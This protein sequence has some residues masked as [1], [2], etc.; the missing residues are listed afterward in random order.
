MRFAI[1]A[2]IGLAALFPL[3]CA[4][5]VDEGRGAGAGYLA[6]VGQDTQS[7]ARTCAAGT[8]LAG[9]DVSYYQGTID[10]DRVANAGVEYAFIRVSDGLTKVDSK[11]NR[12]WAEARR[13]G[14]RRSVYQFFRPH[15]DPIAQANLLL[16]RMGPLEPGDLPPVIDVEKDSGM[17]TSA[18]AARVQQW[19]DHVE[20]QLGVR[21]IIYSGPYFWRDQVG[22][23]SWA[24]DY[25]LWVAHYTTGCPLTPEPW[26]TWT[27]HQYTDRG[28]VDGISGNVDRNF[29]NGTLADLDA[30]T[31]GGSGPGIPMPAACNAMPEAGGVI[32]ETDPCLR[33]NGPA[34]YWRAASGGH[35]SD[36][37]WTGA[38]GS[39]QAV[40]SAEWTLRF[41]TSGAWQVD[42]YLEGGLGT[43]RLATYKVRHADGE[44]TVEVDQSEAD[45]WVT[46]GTWE[47]DADVAGR[48]MLND[49][50]GEPSSLNRRLVVDALA[51][52]PVDV[53]P[54]PAEPPA[55]ECSLP[56]TGGIVEEDG[57]CT[58]FG[59][60][61]EYLRAVEGEGHGG[62]YLW[63]GATSSSQA[64]NTV[65]WD[66]SVATT[67]AW[68]IEAFVEDGA[69]TSQ[70][71]GYSVDH[72]YGTDEVVVDQAAASGF[73]TLGVFRVDASDGAS[74]QLADNTGESSSLDRKI[75][76]D[77][78]RVTPAEGC[79]EVRITPSAGLNVRPAPNTSNSPVGTL[80]RNQRVDWRASVEG[81]SIGGNTLWYRVTGPVSGY[82]AARY[83]AC[84]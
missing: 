21:P 71:A 76:I 61:A 65:V 63:T 19:V 62:S 60:P 70:Q 77:A 78:L 51:I 81:Q 53:M 43:S 69:A 7:M 8:T 79:A 5:E 13:V 74:V 35:G 23:P 57:P 68:R 26:P 25:P 83:A 39:A 67:R 47:F 6:E 59:G 84:E 2:T 44:D 18:V 40:N 3:G 12:N 37:A 29:F 45:G 49:N 30:L 72:D 46:L 41:S 27:F 24:V 17:S 28:R 58:T 56:A 48:V 52:A 54:P 33:L 10:W 20:T 38:T 11:F 82:V 22:S 80:S 15:H 9:I 31:V 14:V 32:D 75:G 4:Y 16:D 42:V 73:V 36:H 55:G 50:T 1:G 66:V 64:V 34:Q